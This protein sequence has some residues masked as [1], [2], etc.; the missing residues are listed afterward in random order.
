MARTSAFSFKGKDI[1]VRKIGEELGVRNVL[2]GSVR[3]AGDRLRV[4]AQLINVADGY[5]LWSE[6]FD[7]ELKDVFA[8][9]DEISAKIVDILK[10]KLSVGATQPTAKR[11]RSREAHD[12]YLRGLY[13]QGQESSNLSA[14]GRIGRPVAKAAECFEQ[15]A[16]VDPDYAAAHASFSLAC[17]RMMTNG[18]LTA[19]DAQLRAEPAAERALEIDDALAEA[20][21]ALAMVRRWF[22]YDWEGARREFQRAIEISPRDA[23]PRH[24]FGGLYLVATGRTKEGVAEARRALDLDPLSVVVNRGLGQDLYCDRQYD[25]SIR[26]LR[27]SLEMDPN[28]LQALGAL[29][30]AYEANDMPDEVLSARMETLRRAGQ[31]EAAEK[32]RDAYSEGG[33]HGMLRWFI[34]RHLPKAQSQVNEAFG[35]NR[36]GMVAFFYSRL[37]EVDEAFRWLEVAVVRRA[38][39]LSFVRIDP[40]LDNL[41]SDPRWNGIMKMMGFDD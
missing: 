32:L 1:D 5:H 16:L 25:E 27:H 3:R 36:A 4:T 40:A 21:Q 13:H 39:L 30:R 26:Q 41:R 22:Y 6:R 19:E 34:Q 20:H 33:E 38:G 2:E 37:G 17:T 35:G 8:I 15:A 29:A 7:R 12:L 28:N 31:K 18:F 11:T 24:L 14:G 23:L 9:Q 10:V